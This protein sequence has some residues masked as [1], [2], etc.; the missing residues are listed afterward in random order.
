MDFGLTGEIEEVE[1]GK[2]PASF[3]QMF[4]GKA[5]DTAI[6][7]SADHW[8]LKPNYTKYST[9]LFRS[10]SSA[11]EQVSRRYIA[12]KTTTLTGFFEIYILVG[13]MAQSQ[14]SAF[15]HSLMFAQEYGILAAGME[16]RPFVPVTTIVLGGVPKDMRAVF[17]K[18]KDALSPTEMNAMGTPLQRGRSLRVVP[19]TAALEAT[20]S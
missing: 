8:R 7:K 4:V 12:R 13:S 16:D 18:W 11:K 5:H 17:R 3:L 1:D 14:F 6:P 9:R 20:R 2:E 15:Q 10:H 19:L